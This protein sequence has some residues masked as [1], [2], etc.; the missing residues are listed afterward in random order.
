MKLNLKTTLFIIIL[1]LILGFFL[2]FYNLSILPIFADEAIYIRWSQIM[3][4]DATLRF[5]PLSDGKQPLF[6]WVTIPFFKIFDDPLIAGRFVSVISGILTILG[7][8]LLSFLLFRNFYSAVTSAFI[9]SIIPYLV[10]FD[11]M[12]LVDSLLTALGIWVSIFA[13]FTVLYKRLDFAMITG[14]LLGLAFLTKSPAVFFAILAPCALIFFK[15]DKKTKKFYQILKMLGLYIA[16]YF[17]AFGMHNIMRLG[18]NFHMLALRNKDY[19]YPLSHIFVSPFD[20]F[21]PF[22]NRAFEWY[23]MM[24]TFG[25]VILVFVGICLILLKG[26]K[27]QLFFLLVMGLTPILVTS[28]FAKVYTARYILFTVP[29]F[30]VLASVPFMFNLAFKRLFFLVLVL[31]IIQSIT[32]NYYLLT[33]P[34]LAALPRSE[35][36]GYL[37]EWTAG[38]GIYEISQYLRK[39]YEKDPNTK[40]IVGTEGYFGTLPDGLQLYL[41][42]IPQITIIG[43]GI[44]IKEL[45]KSLE[46]SKKHGN[47]TY[48]VINDSRLK[49]DPN[50]IGLEEVFSFPKASREKGSKE[51]NDLGNYETL[52]FYRVN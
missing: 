21:L 3:K 11:R 47:K 4:A 49:V 46:E 19:V 40:I 10:F 52:F 23:F 45:P 22:I 50:N 39:E 31:F 42:D 16:I 13:V 15:F 8:F 38:T 2:R 43:V 18:P 30:C 28:E 26:Y 29:Y 14:G 1:I 33:N 35:R 37:E 44:D 5:L 9:A 17:I 20:P 48:L 36:S 41:N 51:Y 25:F 24:G 32:F 6:M 34:A 7:V 12:A 27:K